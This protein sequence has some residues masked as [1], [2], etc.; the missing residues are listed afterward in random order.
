MHAAVA[1]EKNVILLNTIFPANEFY[2]YNRG[3]ILG[4]GLKC[5]A[6]Y[7]AQFDDKCLAKNCMELITP[8]R[9]MEQIAA[10]NG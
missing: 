10:Q 6:C 1:L 5:Q 7:K 3:A 2:L 9:V 8:A 4:A